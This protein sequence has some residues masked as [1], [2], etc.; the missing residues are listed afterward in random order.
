MKKTLIISILNLFLC[1]NNAFAT[2]QKTPICT[3]LDSSES[4]CVKINLVNGE[5]RYGRVLH[6][7]ED[8]LTYQPCDKPVSNLLEINKIDI[9]RIT[10][11]DG[12]TL[13]QNPQ[14]NISSPFKGKL[15]VI[16]SVLG[17]I[18]AVITFLLTISWL[19]NRDLLL[20]ATAII[21]PIIGFITGIAG[22]TQMKRQPPKYR[23]WKILAW[24]SMITSG[25]IL[26]INI[27][28]RES[29]RF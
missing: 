17:S 11:S 9:L 18:L 8:I 15:S 24:L 7:D 29:L 12:K 3:R 22:L 23:I 27:L 21:A 4:P 2:I 28:L 10:D 19:N 16:L 5:I 1:F 25:A 13:F 14:S 20:S 6:L 26:V